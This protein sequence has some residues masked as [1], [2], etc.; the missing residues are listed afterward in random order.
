LS[1]MSSYLG[2]PE[3]SAVLDPEDYADRDSPRFH[4]WIAR[5]HARFRRLMREVIDA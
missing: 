1:D 2:D 4:E 5:V 3:W